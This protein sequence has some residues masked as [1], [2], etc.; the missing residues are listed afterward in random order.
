VPWAGR[1][2]LTKH[3]GIPSWGWNNSLMSSQLASPPELAFQ[4]I[5]QGLFMSCLAAVAFSRA[6]A[7]LGPSAATAIIALLPVV[8][9]LLAIPVLGE[10]PLPAQWVAI[11]VIGM[12]VCLAAKR[13][14]LRSAFLKRP[15]QG[16]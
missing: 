6:V 16:E 4:V 1:D 12:G 8:A 3:K 13:P 2:A 10:I 5:Y 7:L 14:S 15:A 11:I 9:S